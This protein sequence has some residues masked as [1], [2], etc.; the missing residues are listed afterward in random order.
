[1]IDGR[2]AV[3]V[4]G[5]N[6]FIGRH[7]APFLESKGW[8]VRRALRTPTPKPFEVGI[9]SIGSRTNWVEALAGIDAVVHLAA[10]VHHAKDEQ[11][12]ALYEDTNVQG[13]LHLARSAME[14]GVQQ[15]VFISTVLVNGRS[16]DG[17]PP[18]SEMD[19]LLPRNVYARSKAAAESG[20]QALAQQGAMGITVIRPP[21]VYGA[22]AKGNFKLLKQ[23]IER[24]IPL[25]LGAI[26][27]RRAFISVQNLASFIYA[28]LLPSDSRFEVFL[29]ADKEQ[30]STP[31]FVVRLAKAAGKRARLVYVPV[32]LLNSML[33]LARRPEVRESLIGS[34]ELD[35]SKAAAT[36]WRQPISLDEGLRL[37]VSQ[38]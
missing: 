29:V 8:F 12:V 17:H 36:G 19:R 14:A 32:P 22:G 7:V 34:L 31:E 26:E 4:T 28:R 11:R 16:S 27:N 24:G 3:L 35:L 6:G 13:T 10:R 15:F 25:P 9:E 23:A 20:L 21:L 30:V 33:K 1:M 38:A 18:F 37:A 2:N 5:A